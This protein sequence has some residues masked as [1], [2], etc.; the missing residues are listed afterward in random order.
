[1]FEVTLFLGLPLSEYLERELALLDVNIVNIFINA[2]GGY[3]QRQKFKEQEYLGKFAGDISNPASLKLLEANI[4]SIL[5]KL[6]PS[7]TNQDLQFLLFPVQK[8]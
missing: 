1:M 6:S 8:L 2:Q 7:I 5:A 3:L 4:I